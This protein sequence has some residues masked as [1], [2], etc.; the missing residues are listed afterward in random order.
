MRPGS[1]REWRPGGWC[2]IFRTRPGNVSCGQVTFPAAA[3]V[4]E[5]TSIAAQPVVASGVSLHIGV[6]RT[7][8]DHYA[9]LKTLRGAE[10]DARSMAQLAEAQ[11]FERRVVLVGGDATLGAVR[12]E[13]SRAADHL[14]SGDTFV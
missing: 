10:R 8:P 3:P 2:P 5:G 13:L 7:D 1:I 14:R 9:G 11:A 4:L 6:D 12:H